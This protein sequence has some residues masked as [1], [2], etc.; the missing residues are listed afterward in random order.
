MF[1][2]TL[3]LH[4]DWERHL[5]TALLQCGAREHRIYICSPLRG[6]D[7]AEIQRNMLAARF[8]MYLIWMY[9]QQI[10]RAPHAYLPLF[11]CD[12]NPE[13]RSDAIAIGLSLVAGSKALYVC[14]NRITEG[15]RNEIIQALYCKIPITVFDPDLTDEIR[16]LF[17]KTMTNPRLLRLNED[18]D[19]R[20]LGLSAEELFEGVPCDA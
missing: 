17:R 10:A 12:D 1:T 8:Y 16:R 14:G 11:F 15:M 19:H 3:G 2:C 4:M 20:K 6:A 18:P 5:E 7:W 13:E 9:D